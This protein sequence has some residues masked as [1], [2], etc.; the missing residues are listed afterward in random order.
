MKLNRLESQKKKKIV[1]YISREV[2]PHDDIE[3]I[4]V[5]S[6]IKITK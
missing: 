6:Y 1:A 4:Y 5:N 2:T 3:N